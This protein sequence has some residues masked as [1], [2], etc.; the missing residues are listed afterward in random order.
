MRRFGAENWPPFLAGETRSL[1]NG[2]VD[3]RL[4]LCEVLKNTNRV[5]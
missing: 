4:K 2:K 5:N 3:Q 1:A